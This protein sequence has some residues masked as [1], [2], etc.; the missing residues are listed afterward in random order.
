M[1]PW[2]KPQI[3]P[4]YT[5]RYS[6]HTPPDNPEYTQGAPRP[7]GGQSKM[8]GCVCPGCILVVS[9]DAYG[10][11]LGCISVLLSVSIGN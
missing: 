10:V 11:Y 1:G 9:R 6:L 4:R 3:D 5:D 7:W 2:D 8:P